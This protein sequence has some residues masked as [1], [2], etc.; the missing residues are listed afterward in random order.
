M[1]L[2]PGP[3]KRRFDC[4]GHI[5]PNFNGALSMNVRQEENLRGS[6]VNVDV[7]QATPASSQSLIEQTGGL[8]QI[9]PSNSHSAP[10]NSAKT[11]KEFINGTSN[12]L[13]A[14]VVF[15]GFAG[16]MITIPDRILGM[17]AAIGSALA[18]ALIIR[19]VWKDLPAKV[20]L[21][22]RLVQFKRVIVFTF[23]T[24][25]AWSHLRYHNYLRD[26]LRVEAVIAIFSLLVAEHS[27]IQRWLRPRGKIN[28]VKFAAM[29][30]ALVTTIL[31]V[32]YLVAKGLDLIAP[33]DDYVKYS[34][35][36][37]ATLLALYCLGV[38]ATLFFGKY[39]IDSSSR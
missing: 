33:V 37:L 12:L 4:Y 25:L 14:L 13:A 17:I 32:P 29:Y 34:G 22:W 2:S 20:L 7:A 10:P 1:Q 16:Y 9:L 5:S 36:G 28:K 15:V 18:A 6:D 3:L 38:L 31:G 21:D 35:I 19:E 11:L 24:V 27:R 39:P 23:F 8:P 26:F 30:A